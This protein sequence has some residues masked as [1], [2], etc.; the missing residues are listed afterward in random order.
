MCLFCGSKLVTEGEFHFC[1]CGYI[2]TD[3][4]S[5]DEVFDMFS[6]IPDTDEDIPY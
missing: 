2:H 1:S 3:T 4:M 5:Y 6:A